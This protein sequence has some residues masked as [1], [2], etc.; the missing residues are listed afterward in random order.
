MSAHRP[1]RSRAPSIPTE[2]L[3][4]VQTTCLL[5]IAGALA[6]A[7]LYLLQPVMIPLALALLV[8]YTLTPFVELLTDRLHLPR[9]LS[10]TLAVALVAGL[11][12]GVGML[13]GTS[14]GRVLESGDAYEQALIE[15]GRDV[16]LPIAAHDLAV[17]P[18]AVAAG[19]LEAEVLEEAA[20]MPVGRWASSLADGIL[21]MLGTLSL[22]MVFAVFMLASD[23]RADFRS[24]RARVARR[25]KRY[26]AIKFVLSLVTGALVGGV[27]ALLGVE[28]ALLLGVLTFALNFVPNIGPLVATALPIPLVIVQDGAGSTLVL[29]I[30][31]PAAIQFVIGALLEPRFL[32]SELRLHPVSVLAALVFWGML[33]GVPGL[34][35]AVPLTT[36]VHISAG[37]TEL[38]RPIADLLSGRFLHPD[39]PEPPPTEPPRPAIRPRQPM[40]TAG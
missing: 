10:V 6:A 31:I 34:L 22:V 30:A 37:S 28:L 19:D 23:A 5:I 1:L 4:R 38:T 24:L 3:V 15:F 12:G 9:T 7:G 39:D 35:L 18:G 33:W 11:L 40:E 27:M 26:L 16:G 2:R 29:A 14:L 17:D 21:G 20:D 13:V 36:A 25:V 32:G 8:S